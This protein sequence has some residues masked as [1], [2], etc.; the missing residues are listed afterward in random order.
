MTAEQ[1]V[2]MQ[3]MGAMGA[4]A[5]AGAVLVLWAVVF[6][7]LAGHPVSTGGLD[8][9]HSLLVRLTTFFPALAV[10]LLHVVVARR[11]ADAARVSQ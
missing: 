7:W 1:T 10:A 2:K 9:V 11:L 6:L 5:T 4:M 3:R 8:W